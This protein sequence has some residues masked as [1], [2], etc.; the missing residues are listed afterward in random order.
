MNQ[1]SAFR[2]LA[3]L[4]LCAAFNAPTHAGG[5]VNHPSEAELKAAVAGGGLVT[6]S[7]DGTIVITSPVLLTAN[8]TIDATGHHITL[9]ALG[10]VRLMAVF[11]GVSATLKNLELFKGADRPEPDSISSV[12]DALGGGIVNQGGNLT[13]E[14]C[15]FFGNQ[16]VGYSSDTDPPS[17]NDLNSAAYGGAIF[18]GGGSLHLR[19]SAFVGNRAIGGSSQT[20]DGKG[21]YGGAIAMHGGILTIESCT[22]DSN[23]ARGGS[24]S[25]VVT[26]AGA[27]VAGA[28][29]TWE[30]IAQISRSALQN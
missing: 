15:L 9:D 21:G 29:L 27:G 2:S 20:F 24:A 4:I 11:P 8:T 3:T 26:H 30:T 22:F 25:A 23:E 1:H 12:P 17:A 19:N 18:S 10:N 14:S 7:F 5:V 28:L 16:A 13:I 6:F